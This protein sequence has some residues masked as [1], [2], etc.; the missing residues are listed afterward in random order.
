L[1][2]SLAEWMGFPALYTEY[3]GAPPP[4]SGAR[5]ALIAPYGPFT[6]GDGGV[7]YLAVQNDRE[8]TRFCADVVGQPALATDARFATNPS[9][10][11]HRDALEAAINTAFAALTAPEVIA[12]LEAAGIANARM[13]TVD[14]FL[15]HPQLDARGRWRE[16]GSEAGPVRVLAPPFA[17]DDEDVPMGPVPAV[18]EHTE[19]IL[20]EL[21]VA[22]QAIADWRRAGIA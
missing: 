13:N 4:R 14:D 18:G 1:F 12:R 20:R 16:I 22:P 10:V 21:G 15:R 7:V 17:I 11:Q 2:D 19:A 3:G 9:R 6:A 5:N 8:W